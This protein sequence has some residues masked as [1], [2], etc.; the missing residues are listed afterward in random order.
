MG[1]T[2]GKN[3]TG[4]HRR[5]VLKGAAWSV[6]VVAAAVAVPAY[7]A[8]ACTDYT[9]GGL[10]FVPNGSSYTATYGVQSAAGPQSLAGWSLVITL[11]PKAGGPSIIVPAQT[12][13]GT[14]ITRTDLPNGSVQLQISGATGT[15]VSFGGTF[16]GGYTGS[17]AWTKAAC[18]INKG[19][20][21][22]AAIPPFTGMSATLNATG[23]TGAYLSGSATFTPPTGVAA[24]TNATL[25]FTVQQKQNKH[26]LIGSGTTA[27]TVFSGSG[28]SFTSATS[29][30]DNITYVFTYAGSVAAG[31]TST[32]SFRLNSSSSIGNGD[33]P[34]S[35][36]ATRT[37]SGTQFV[38]VTPNV[39]TGT[40]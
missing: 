8:S 29:S 9:V 26:V 21:F 38:T 20:D 17:A 40:W 34:I 18:S 3:A 19:I 13:S 6:P 5:T 22:G 28:W 11:V 16:T 36:G 39:T 2:L 10:G 31:A 4:L 33:L 7:A 25:A 27:A 24:V 23:R 35:I 37:L 1:E 32:L 30:G 12:T 15:S 14:T